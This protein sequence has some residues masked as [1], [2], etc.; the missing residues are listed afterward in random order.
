MKRGQ[1]FDTMMLVI[2][3]IVAVAILG[4]LLGFLGGIGGFGAKAKDVIPD[5]VKKVQQKGF[6]L[7]PKDKVEFTKGDSIYRADAKGTAPISTDSVNFMCY[8]SANSICS[9]SSDTPLTVSQHGS[10][11]C[12]E[13]IA[14][15]VVVCFNDRDSTYIVGIGQ[16]L[17]YVRGE[18]EKEC[19]LT[20]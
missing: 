1:A 20:G 8:D 4:M 2:S 12:N 15:A 5:L 10:I 13:N 14:V 7:E 9:S 19:G 3:V 11:V 6:G 16:S 18:A 17:S